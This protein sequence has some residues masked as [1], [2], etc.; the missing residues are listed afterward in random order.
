MVLCMIVFV[1][2]LNLYLYGYTCYTVSGLMA[3]LPG[4]HDNTLDEPLNPWL[5]DQVS[6]FSHIPELQTNYRLRAYESEVDN[7][8]QG[9]AHLCVFVSNIFSM[10]PVE[11][12]LHRL[13]HHDV[14]FE[15]RSPSGGW[16]SAPGKEGAVLLILGIKKTY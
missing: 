10:E 1:A 12:E 11:P 9:Y 4:I 8:Y 13:G 3:S 15:V 5:F 2:C 6:H 14:Q 16:I 7:Y